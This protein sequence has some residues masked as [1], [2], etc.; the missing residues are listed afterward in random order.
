MKS[1]A[2]FVLAAGE[3]EV[4]EEEGAG[5]G[6]VEVE[7]DFADLAEVYAAEVGEGEAE[8]GEGDMPEEDAFW[9]E[10]IFYGGSAG[11]G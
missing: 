7:G 4:G 1:A 11:V 6:L 10:G 2:V 3:E 8:G 9:P 5:G